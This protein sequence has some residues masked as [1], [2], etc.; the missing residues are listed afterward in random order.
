M[1]QS[2]NDLLGISPRSDAELKHT[3]K[4]FEAKWERKRLETDDA[5]M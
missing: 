4:R 5:R 3:L 2:P 1:K